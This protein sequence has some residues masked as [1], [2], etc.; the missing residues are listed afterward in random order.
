MTN[1]V[2]AH[3]DMDCFFAACEIKKTPSLKGKAFLVGG[4][5]DS[6]RGVVCT[7]TYEARNY[8]VHSAMPISRAISLRPDI[9]CVQTDHQFYSQESNKVMNSLSSITEQ[10]QQVSIDEAYLD[11]TE[12]VTQFD[13]W[14]RAG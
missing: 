2:I 3:V 8:G 4:S 6:R 1:Q 13:T 10:F 12:F 7:A 9:L 14:Q 5:K 11:I